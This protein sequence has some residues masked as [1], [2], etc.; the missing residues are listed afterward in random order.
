[1]AILSEYSL[2][3]LFTLS[4]NGTEPSKTILHPCLCDRVIR[5]EERQSFPLSLSTTLPSTANI[6]ESNYDR[7]A[8]HHAHYLVQSSQKNSI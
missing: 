3:A 1:M 2:G 4:P 8:L 7:P 6:H 5:D